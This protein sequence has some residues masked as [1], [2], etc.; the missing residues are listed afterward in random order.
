M[1]S[2]QIVFH[3]RSR[4]MVSHLRPRGVVSYILCVRVGA[5]VLISQVSHETNHRLECRTKSDESSTG[6]VKLER[7]VDSSVCQ[8]PD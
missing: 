2:A 4:K 8:Q 6:V 1:P 3:I 7:S 5:K